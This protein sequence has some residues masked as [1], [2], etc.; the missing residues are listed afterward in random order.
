MI[1]YFELPPLAFGPFIVQPGALLVAIAILSGHFLLLRSATRRGFPPSLVAG[2]SAVLLGGGLLLGHIVKLF[3]LPNAWDA[4]QAQP[5][6]LL[7]IFYGQASLGGLAGGLLAGVAYLRWRRIPLYDALVLFDCLA[8]VFP[9][10]WFFGRLHCALI[11]D[12][13]GIRTSSWLGVRYPDAIR[14][15]LAILELLF[16]PL[17]LAIYR[18]LPPA[19]AHRPGARLATFLAAYGLFRLGLDT[20]HLEVVR[21]LGLSVDQWASLA[22]L[23]AAVVVLYLG[24]TPGKTLVAANAGGNVALV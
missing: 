24:R 20:L 5:L 6:L 17:L 19:L 22:A 21:Y 14:Y 8:S 18:L 16:L 12:H 9:Y 2:F 4:I 23:L 10:A 1:P 13:P 15:D 7:L 3:Y 11:H